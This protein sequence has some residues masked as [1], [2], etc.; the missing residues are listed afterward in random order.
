MADMFIVVLAAPDEFVR[1]TTNPP[2]EPE[3]DTLSDAPEPYAWALEVVTFAF[4]PAQPV[5]LN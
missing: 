4:E 1:V 3:V 5:M 2:E